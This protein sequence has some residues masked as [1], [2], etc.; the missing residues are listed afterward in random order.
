M[1]SGEWERR[2]LE[3]SILHFALPT[4]HSK[5]GADGETRTPVGRNARQFTKLLLSLLSHAGFEMRN[6]ECGVRNGQTLRGGRLFIPH[7]PLCTLHSALKLVGRH[8][9]APCSAA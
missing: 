2:R 7:S 9:A 1:K 6:A 5:D 4:P 8:G 3:N